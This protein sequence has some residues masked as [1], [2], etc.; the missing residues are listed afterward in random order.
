[1]VDVVFPIRGLSGMRAYAGRMNYA[2][3]MYAEN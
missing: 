1:M 2:R 3:K